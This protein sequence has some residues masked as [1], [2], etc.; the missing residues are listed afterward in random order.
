MSKSPLATNTMP[1]PSPERKFLLEI[2]ECEIDFI[3]QAELNTDTDTHT[4]K[5]T[6]TQ[7][8]DTQHHT[9]THTNTHTHTH[10]HSH[11]HTHLYRHNPCETTELNDGFAR[12]DSVSM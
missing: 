9:H 7:N 11:T 10:T 12:C 2:P 5:H 3:N 1:P 6:H 8:T 4:P